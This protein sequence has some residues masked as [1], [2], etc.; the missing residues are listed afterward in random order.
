MLQFDVKKLQE[1]LLRFLRRS[2]VACCQPLIW[3]DY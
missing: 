1:N 2:A 3:R